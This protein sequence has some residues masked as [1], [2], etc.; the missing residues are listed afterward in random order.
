MTLGEKI[1]FYRELKKMTQPEL[2]QL[3]GIPAGTI[4]KYEINNRKPKS[5]QRKKIAE[6]LNISSN[7]LDDISFNTIGDAAPYLIEL[8]KKGDIQFYGTLNSDGKYCTDD[9]KISFSSATLRA[10]LKEWADKKIIID[11]LRIDA[12]NSPDE[13]VKMY[14]LKRADELQKE[15]ELSMVDSQIYIHPPKK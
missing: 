2:S 13:Q 3:S 4:R 5:E 6:A 10:F 8:A 7:A 14:S 15:M 1:R 12:N 9:I 11:K